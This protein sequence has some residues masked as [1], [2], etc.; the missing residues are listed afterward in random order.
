MKNKTIFLVLVLLL[1]GCNSHS[2]TFSDSYSY[3]ETHHW[4]EATCEH[5]DIIKDSG[6]H[7]LTN[8]VID[9]YPTEYETGKKHRECT[10]CPY[11]EEETIAKLPH[12]HKAGEP[13]IENNVE[14]TCLEDGHY[15]SVVYCYECHEEMSRTEITVHSLGHD[16]VH[17]EGKSATCVENG[18]K[19]YDTCTRCDYSTFESIPATG[20]QHINTRED[21][22]IEP[23]CTEDGSYILVYY[24]EDDKAIISTEKIV[25]PALGHDLIH[26][27]GQEAT[28]T[29]DGYEEYD[30]C[31]RCD[32]STFKTIAA[33]G[34]QHIAMR[35]ENRIEATCTEDGSYDLVSYCEDDNVVISTEQ[36]IIPALGHDY[37]G[38]ET[39]PDYDHEGY[40]TYTC[41]RCHDTYTKKTSDQLIHTYSEDWSTDSANH[42]KN[43]LDEGY[44][45]LCAEKGQHDFEIE[46]T[47]PTGLSG[48]YTTHTCKTCGY[49]YT[50]NP[51]DPLTY[52]VTWVDR[53]GTV[54]E[55]DYEVTYGTEPTYNGAYHIHQDTY[56]EYRFLEWSP[57]IKEVTEDI[58]YTAT[59]SA[60]P[61]SFYINYVLDG[62][63]ADNKSSYDVTMD[64]FT[65]NDPIKDGY[66][67]I[68]WTWVGNNTPIK[69]VTIDTSS[70]ENYRFF[71]NY[72]I[73]DYSV[74][75][76]LNGGTNNINNPTS[77]Q[78][79]DDVDLLNANKDNY[80]FDGWYLDE[81]FAQKVDNLKGFFGD[82]ELFAKFIP[83]TFIATFTYDFVRTYNINYYS[84]GELVNSVSFSDGESIKLY[85]FM[86]TKDG[87]IFDGWFDSEGNVIKNDL[88][89][90]NSL[91]VYAHWVDTEEGKIINLYK[92]SIL[93]TLNTDKSND[94]LEVR[95]Y[96]PAFLVE[97]TTKIDARIN[98]TNSGDDKYYW[99]LS[100]YLNDV[101][102]EE[103]IFKLNYYSS[104]GT[105]VYINDRT[106]YG[107]YTFAAGHFYYF[108]A[109]LFTGTNCSAQALFN[110][111]GL[112]HSDNE[113]VVTSTNSVIETFDS[114]ALTPI[115]FKDG[116]EFVGWFD[117]E[118]NPIGDIWKY[119]SNKT[120]VPKW[121][122]I[123]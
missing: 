2:H 22:R 102:T 62:G 59:Y 40:I 74:E 88:S 46:V 42:W 1:S 41:S 66:T 107:D 98:P 75:Y 89:I 80:D 87:Y 15:E 99:S 53:D 91:N 70:A 57:A 36:K 79:T 8:W 121:K 39:L 117:E 18:Y 49:S 122:P 82:L 24:C 13:V 93:K 19:A 68:G 118:D 76:V 25:L 84:D 110:V 34:H 32:Y 83:H 31:S 10:I 97:T 116:Y 73:N 9:K 23:T 14:P 85:D 21:N 7:E 119:T 77:Y 105:I 103:Q 6:K 94:L 33:T 5:T 38:V 17:H 30:T 50:D 55:T 113:M 111:Y 43:C 44:E 45:D 35:E 54:L 72:I 4:K 16:I 60:S 123:D 63:K 86:P 78:I 90:Y 61:I 52:T 81:Q 51:T 96:V 65:L 108:V 58:T 12:T 27:K 3:D 67:F 109:S 26:H 101:T 28:C 120:F 37:E 95:F 20:H 69:E 106:Y 64:D 114:A 71:A 47:E 92:N 11:H 29:E 48:G 104:H 115:L 100:A 112:F 56:Y